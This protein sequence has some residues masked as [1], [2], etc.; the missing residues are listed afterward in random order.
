MIGL[1]YRTG[2]ANGK[3]KRIRSFGIFSKCPSMSSY[4]LC[5]KLPIFHGLPQRCLRRGSRQSRSPGHAALTLD[6][7]SRCSCPRHLPFH[8]VAWEWG[9]AFAGLPRRQVHCQE[10]GCRGLGPLA[11]F[12][13]FYR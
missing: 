5:R 4:H 1:E 3:F 9:C 12:P 13:Y 10:S 7:P 8:A 11:Q 2:L 6:I